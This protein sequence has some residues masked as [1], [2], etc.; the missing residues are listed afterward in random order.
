MLAA[1]GADVT[2]EFYINDRG[3]QMD[4]FGESIMNAAHGRPA[5]EQGYHGSYIKDIAA[6]DRGQ[7]LGHHEAPRSTSSS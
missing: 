2:R 5:P 1:Q 6:R 3:V 7:R 4:R